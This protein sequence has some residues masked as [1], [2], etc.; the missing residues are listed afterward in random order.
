MYIQGRQSEMKYISVIILK[1][2]VSVFFF[3][4]DPIIFI[5]CIL[6]L[7]FKKKKSIFH[8]QK[9]LRYVETS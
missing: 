4:R 8:V 9:K 6:F 1:T 3:L 7:D 2:F 5:R